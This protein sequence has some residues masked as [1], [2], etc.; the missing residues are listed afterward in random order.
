MI[1]KKTNSLLKGVKE[2][3][4]LNN[5]STVENS[6]DIYAVGRCPKCNKV[7]LEIDGVYACAGKSSDTC[8]YMMPL[9]LDGEKISFDEILKFGRYQKM[10]NNGYYAQSKKRKYLWNFLRGWFIIKTY[11]SR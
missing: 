11:M 5:N 10:M 7:V 3:L 1:K 9:M 2:I 8:D 4:S 6:D